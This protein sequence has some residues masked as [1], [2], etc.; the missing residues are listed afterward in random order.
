MFFSPI[1]R[2]VCTCVSALFVEMTF[3]IWQANTK[4]PIITYILHTYIHMYVL[5]ITNCIC[6]FFYYSTSSPSFPLWSKIRYVVLCM[7][8]NGTAVEVRLHSASFSLKNI[9]ILLEAFC[10]MKNDG[11]FKKDLVFFKVIKILV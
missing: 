1:N 2:Y 9:G 3:Q 4:I 10:V 5:D 7:C 6:F 8:K 11:L